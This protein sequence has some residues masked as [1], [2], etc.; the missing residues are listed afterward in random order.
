M[1]KDIAFYSTQSVITD[2]KQYAG[3]L[4]VLPDDPREL[5]RVAQGLVIHGALGELYGMNFSKKT[6]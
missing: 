1:K 6:G 4:E 3:G 2:P 5:L